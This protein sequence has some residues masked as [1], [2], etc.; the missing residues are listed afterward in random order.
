MCKKSLSTKT[1]SLL[2]T[3]KRRHVVLALFCDAKDEEKYKHVC[4]IVNDKD[5]LIK[6]NKFERGG[7]F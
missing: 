4:F 6:I 1:K 2:L 3:M 7:R 5:D